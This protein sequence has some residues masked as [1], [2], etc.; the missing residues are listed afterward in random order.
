MHGSHE[1]ALGPPLP[2]DLTPVPALDTAGMPESTAAAVEALRRVVC[3][4]HSVISGLI[5]SLTAVRNVLAAEQAR[6]A[7][8][9]AEVAE[10]QTV[11]AKQ[12]VVSPGRATSARAA[13]LAS[14]ATAFFTP[15]GAAGAAS[16]GTGAML[17]DLRAPARPP[18]HAPVA[19]PGGTGAAARG[20]SDGVAGGAGPN[21]HGGSDV[22]AGA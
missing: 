10:L 12:R 11:V 22:A 3:E 6:S 21:G 4:Q 15:S 19:A 14:R 9:R 7:M 18:P 2:K 16:A 13:V 8:L 5:A 17:S 1:D 20:T